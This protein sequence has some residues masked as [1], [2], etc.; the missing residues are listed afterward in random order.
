M[1]RTY[2]VYMISSKDPN[3][4]AKYI[5][6][7]FDLKKRI[8]QHAY[9]A[10]TTKYESHN[11]HLYEFIREMGGWDNFQVTP[12]F[13]NL[14]L[15]EAV[16]K[17]AETI[18]DMRPYLNKVLPLRSMKEYYD[19]HREELLQKQVL[20]AYYQKEKYRERWTLNN[21]KNRDKINAAMKKYYAENKEEL[22]KKYKTKYW[23]VCGRLINH[24][25]RK[26]HL[27]RPAHRNGLKNFCREVKDLKK[28]ILRL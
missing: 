5:G 28:E 2:C 24:R 9:M 26:E 13:E 3:N 12:L 15:I 21:E 14:T 7:T 10:A 4:T 1:E 11:Y 25:G 8:Y 6:R 22:Q 19:E 27:K 18:A 20:Y 17:E 16:V 23:C